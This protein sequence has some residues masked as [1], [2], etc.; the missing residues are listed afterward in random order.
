[1]RGKTEF[2]VKLFFFWGSRTAEKSSRAATFAFSFRCWFATVPCRPRIPLFDG[3]CRLR[4]R[5]TLLRRLGATVDD[6]LFAYICP[7][8]HSRYA[9]SRDAFRRLKRRLATPRFVTIVAVDQPTRHSNHGA[10]IHAY[11][12]WGRMGSGEVGV[13]SS[14]TMAGSIAVIP[15][16]RAPRPRR[17]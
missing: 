6:E 16:P 4:H 9:D 12:P 17:V 8:R 1:M 3:S 11:A 5:L 13:S 14:R 10:L 7:Y 2:A 15:N